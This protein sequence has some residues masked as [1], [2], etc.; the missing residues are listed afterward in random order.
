MSINIVAPV[1]L[2]TVSFFTNLCLLK[3]DFSF[4]CDQE[5]ECVGMDI[6]GGIP[7]TNVD[8]TGYYSCLNA[9]IEATDTEASEKRIDCGGSFSCLDANTIGYKTN[10]DFAQAETRCDGLYV[11]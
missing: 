3:G 8:C 10:G 1:I 11:S 7:T 5:R 6:T 9:T 2:F 4:E